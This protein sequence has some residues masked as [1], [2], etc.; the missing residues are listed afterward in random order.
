MTSA[1]DTKQRG[2]LLAMIL[3]RAPRVLHW[4]IIPIYFGA[5]LYVC[6]FPVFLL[7]HLVGAS[8]GALDLARV[9][10]FMFGSAS[11]GG[12]VGGFV[13]YGMASSQLNP[14]I[15][16]WP[17]AGFVTGATMT[18]ICYFVFDL[19]EPLIPVVLIL[20]GGPT[21]LG[22]LFGYLSHRSDTKDSS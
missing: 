9:F 19:Q 12:L 2:N 1:G 17:S 6:A 22:A 11:I 8:I 4:A 20:F 3:H 5:F 15:I 10:V 16:A 18:L 13:R 14:S 7:G 21:L